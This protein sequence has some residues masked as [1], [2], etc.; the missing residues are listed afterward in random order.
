MH[1][2]EELKTSEKVGKKD[3]GEEEGRMKERGK[4]SMKKGKKKNSNRRLTL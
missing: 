2:I 1:L 3:R 4:N